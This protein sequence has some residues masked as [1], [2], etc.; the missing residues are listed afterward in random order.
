MADVKI[1]DLSES[2]NPAST[3]IIEWRFLELVRKLHWQMQ[4]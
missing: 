2:T 4:L 3:D 1:S